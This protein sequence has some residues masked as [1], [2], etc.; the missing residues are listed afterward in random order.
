MSEPGEFGYM[1]AGARLCVCCCKPAFMHRQEK[2]LTQ[3]ASEAVAKYCDQ[4]MTSKEVH[5]TYSE[6]HNLYFSLTANMLNGV[7]PLVWLQ[8]NVSD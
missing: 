8:D 7:L 2:N 6:L 4:I 3:Q 1:H 5:V